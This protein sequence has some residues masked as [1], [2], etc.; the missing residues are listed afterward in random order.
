MQYKSRFMTLRHIETVR[1]YLDCCCS[2]LAERGRIHDQ[3]KLE[4]PEVDIFAEHIHKLRDLQYGSQEYH[5]GL[6]AMKPAIEHHNKCNRHHPEYHVNG[7]ND[8]NLFDLLEMLVDW[9]A[10]SMRSETGNILNSLKINQKRFGYSEEM[11]QLLART[12]EYIEENP[13]FHKAEES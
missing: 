3:S 11:K 13:I 7:I 12:I 1:N 6:V 4:P 8:M 10:S 2:L 9:R 5:D